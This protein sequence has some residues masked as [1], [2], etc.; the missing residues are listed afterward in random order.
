M[1]SCHPTMEHENVQIGFGYRIERAGN[2]VRLKRG[3]TT[4]ASQLYDFNKGGRLFVTCENFLAEKKLSIT[5]RK[6]QY[7]PFAIG[8]D[9]ILMWEESYGSEEGQEEESEKR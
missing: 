8:S 2:V 9:I 5:V 4:V 6:I 3:E 1:N 7:E